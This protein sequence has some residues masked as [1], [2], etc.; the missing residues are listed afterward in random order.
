MAP[1]VAALAAL[2]WLSLKNRP[3]HLATPHPER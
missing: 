3:P 1:S 2:F